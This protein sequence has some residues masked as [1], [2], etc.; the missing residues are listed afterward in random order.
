MSI[1]RRGT[2]GDQ[3]R[4]GEG[5]VLREHGDIGLIDLSMLIA[6]A[7]VTGRFVD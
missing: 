5:L 6:E 7:S 1:G 4:Q 3:R 2:D